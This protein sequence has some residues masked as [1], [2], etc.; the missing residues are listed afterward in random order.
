[1][2]KQLHPPPSEQPHA[3]AT[4]LERL[5]DL[6]TETYYSS[7]RVGGIYHV[8]SEPFE[9]WLNVD[10]IMTVFEKRTSEDLALELDLSF[11]RS[12]A[13]DDIL[14]L[15]KFAMRMKLKSLDEVSNGI[16]ER[17]VR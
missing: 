14:D 1:M 15:W 6:E 16:D 2:H 13:T 17:T 9:V 10:L 3:S 5:A 8:P 12:F 7:F 11:R 4:H